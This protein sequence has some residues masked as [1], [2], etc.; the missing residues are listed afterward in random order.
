MAEGTPSAQAGPSDWRTASRRSSNPGPGRPSKERMVSLNSEQDREEVLREAEIN[1][2][3]V[4]L[5]TQ[6]EHVISTSRPRLGI[7]TPPDRTD[8]VHSVSAL[9]TSASDYFALPGAP[10]LT[11]VTTYSSLPPSPRHDFSFD[12]RPETTE[13]EEVLHRLQRDTALD[14]EDEVDQFW[15]A[16]VGDV[17]GED[18]HAVGTRSSVEVVDKLE[19]AIELDR[20][21]T[22]APGQVGSTSVWNLLIDEDG[23]EEW[24]GWIVDGKWERI[25][26]FLAVP[27]A[28]EKVTLFGALLCLDGFLYNFTILPFRATFAVVR[29]IRLI[30]DRKPVWPIPPTQLHSLLRML[31]LVIPT[32]ILLCG[33]DASKM[34]HSVRGQDTIKLYVIFNALEIADRLCCAFG[35]DVLDTLFAKETLAPTNRVSGRGRKRQQ[36][37]PLFF[38]ALA[39]GY[40]LC[41][42]LIY[43]YMLVSLNVAINSYDYTLL[44][45]LISNQF[46]EIKGSV[47]KKFEKENLFQIMCADIVER[48]QLGLM[49]S[50]IALRNMIE[51]AG[52]DIAFLP[53]SFVRGKHLVDAIMSPVLFVIVSEMLVDWL[54][55][56]FITKFNH[57][58]ASVYERFTD[59]LAKDVLLAGSLSSKRTVRG[60]NHPI[61]LDQ[62]PLVARRMGFASIPLACLVIRIAAQALG[63]LTSSSHHTDADVGMGEGAWAW[64]ALK[65][66]GWIGV[67]LSGWGCLVALKVFL[68]LSLLS[69]AALRREGMDE[70]EAEDVMNDYGR[71]PVGESKEEAEYNAQTTEYLSQDQDDL[72]GYQSPASAASPNTIFRSGS[73]PARN[74]STP[75]PG[76]ETRTNTSG[77]KSSKWKLEDVE[78]WTM[79]K[80]IW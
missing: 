25:S 71:N 16:E 69:F 22:P 32:A 78:R 60:R 34:Y 79:V 41:H 13:L 48:F 74:A 63:M 9:Y 18:H 58:R 54:K 5:S 44:S 68:G 42:T 49:L 19:K 62:S 33:T 46:V 75:P 12:H 59:I 80:R 73:T 67:G 56:A 17:I 29:L 43:F 61:L 28:V 1:H 64:T 3:E 45:L 40:V 52:S 50:V 26:N 23:A 65:W 14:I 38:F 72:P 21:D 51:M 2:V 35:Q 6:S 53:K 8:P 7:S 77:K 66:A 37:R 39:L 27:L 31:L 47:F 30:L 57:V 36:A 55:H 76:I 4:A 11:R 10:Q 24:D 20:P 70:R 15:E